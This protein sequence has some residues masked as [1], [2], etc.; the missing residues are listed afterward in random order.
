MNVIS[1]FVLFN[2]LICEFFQTHILMCVLCEQD[3]TVNVVLDSLLYKFILWLSAKIP[4][5]TFFYFVKKCSAV[6]S[7][8]S[9]VYLTT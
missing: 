1:Y 6:L 5:Q 2:P 9:L 8:L 7:S 3:A 4:L